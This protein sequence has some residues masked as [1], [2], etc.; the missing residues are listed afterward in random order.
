[1]AEVGSLEA[2]L[3]LAE[4]GVKSLI[5]ALSGSLGGFVSSSVLFPLDLIKTKLQSGQGWKEISDIVSNSEYG[6]LV[7]WKHGHVRGVQSSI[8]KFLYFYNFEMLM[9]MYK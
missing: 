3:Q 1:M 9:Q 4:E 2:E 6:Y 5:N 8:E 7:L